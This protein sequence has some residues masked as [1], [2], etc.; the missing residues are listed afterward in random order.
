MLFR[1]S[2]AHPQL[3]PPPTSPLAL[4]PSYQDSTTTTPHD[5]IQPFPDLATSHCSDHVTSFGCLLLRSFHSSLTPWDQ[6]RTSFVLSPRSLSGPGVGCMPAAAQPVYLCRHTTLFLWLSP[7]TLPCMAVP[8]PPHTLLAKAPSFSGLQCFR[9]SSD[10]YGT[11]PGRPRGPW[12][13]VFFGSSGASHMQ[14]AGWGG[15]GCWLK[16]H[17]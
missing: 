11:I 13:P 12:P 10:G 4:T 14:G 8:L 2:A 6:L 5:S 15:E 16:I 17:F 1:S 9:G 7:A 3:R